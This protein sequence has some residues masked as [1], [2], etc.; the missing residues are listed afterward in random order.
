M[1]DSF[2]ERQQAGA[3]LNTL[4]LGT[5][6]RGKVEE[7]LALL[8]SIPSLQVMTR[9]DVP[10]SDVAETGA[11]FL[12]NAVLKARGIHHQTGLPVL[13]EDAG[14]EVGA[15]DGKPGVYSARYS[16]PGATD[17]TNVR[18]LL[19]R[20]NGATDR[21]ARFVDVACLL[22]PDGRTFITTGILEGTIATAPSGD[23]GF[24]YDPIF[25][26]IGAQNTLAQLPLEEKNRISHRRDAI[27]RLTPILE[28]LVATNSLR[29]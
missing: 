11:T 17:E 25:V 29:A 23:A 27:R 22:L 13:A 14:L 5:G 24:G 20:L 26:P 1:S 7:L 15:L 9:D 8:D 2:I 10:F 28:G 12:D 16:G 4:L 6:N 19:D 21:R 3:E 18:L